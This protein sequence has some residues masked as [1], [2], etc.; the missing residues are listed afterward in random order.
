[1]KHILILGAG[2]MQEPAIDA[3]HELGFDVTV[4]DGNSNAY[5]KNKAEHFEVIDLKYTEK[6]VSRALELH[7]IKAFSAIFTAG[8]DF[9]F[10]V[11][12]VAHACGLAAHSVE[13]AKNASDKVIMRSCFDAAGVPSPQYI[14]VTTNTIDSDIMQFVNT[15][16]YPIVVKPCDNMGARGC[17]LVQTKQE[18]FEAIDDA[19]RYSKTGRAI[20]EEYMDG[21]EFSIDA[22]VYNG[23][24]TITGFADRHIFYPPYFIEMGHSM[25]TSITGQSYN[26]LVSTFVKGIRALGLTHGAAKADLKL[27]KK[28]VMVG[29]IAARL[30]GGYMS[31]WTFPYASHLNLTKEALLIALDN[32]PES[33]FSKRKKIIENIAN[34]S[35]YEYTCT[36]HCIERAWVSIPGSVDTII[37]GNDSNTKNVFPRV[38]EGDCV[39][40]PVNNVEKA[41][42]VICVGQTREDAID[43]AN[44]FIK[45]TVLLLQKNNE[46]T[47]AFLQQD[48]NTDFPPSAFLLPKDIYK[49]IENLP[50]EPIIAPVVLPDFLKQYALTKDWNG[51]SLQETID[52]FNEYIQTNG[53]KQG[54]PNTLLPNYW[55]C[56]IRGGIQGAL[57]YFL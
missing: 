47:I 2:L 36:N 11:S 19:I 27:T 40:F 38:V 52:M 25:P 41:G 28:G 3:A 51:R 17:R 50:Q 7:E 45:G 10:A 13:A 39:T 48:L 14:E 21:P 24:V 5:C 54:S 37:L 8:T 56:L 9:S 22:L 46:K 26:E 32:I 31:G 34:F 18:L 49:K 55:T 23:E 42:N 44:D 35:V 43:Y 30:S 12:S 6:L 4:F 57:F 29:E 1:M 16:N 15:I 33:L 20:V 53:L